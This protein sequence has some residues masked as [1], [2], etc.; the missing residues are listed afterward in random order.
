M[1]KTLTIYSSN[2]VS[3][4]YDNIYSPTFLQILNFPSETAIL[5]KKSH[6]PTLVPMLFLSPSTNKYQ[7]YI[8]YIKPLYY[9]SRPRKT[10]K[11]LVNSKKSSTFAT[12]FERNT[13]EN[14]ARGVAQLAS[15]LAWGARGRKFESFR[16]DEGKGVVKTPFFI[17]PHNKNKT[18]SL[19]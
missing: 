7:P 10:K 9:N 5:Q 2:T 19:S 17:S 6:H 1:T 18:T 11:N 15:A 16:P 8:Q 13:I 12:V 4:L 3:T 14:T